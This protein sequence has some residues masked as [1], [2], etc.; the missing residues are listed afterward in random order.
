VRPELPDSQPGLPAGRHVALIVGAT[1]LLAIGV[2]ALIAKAAGFGEVRDATEEADTMWFVVCLLAEV[3]S[4]S[5]YAIVVREALRRE[6]EPTI[7][8]GLGVHITLASL[9]AIRI[10][11]AAGAGGLAVT[12]WCFPRARFSVDEAFVRVLGLNTLVYV[13]FGAGA[14]CAALVC[15]LGIWGNAPLALAMPWLVAAPFCYAAARFVIAPARVGRLSERRG[16]L[17]RRAFGYA[18]GGTAWVRDFIRTPGGRRA[19][20]AATV[21]W[22]GDIACLWAALHSIGIYLPLSELVLAYA[23]GYAATVLPLPF[24]G[25]GGVDAA[26]TFALT[27]SG[28]RSLPP[29]S[30]WRCTGSSVSGSRPFRPSRLSSSSRARAAAWSGWPPR[31]IP[32]CACSSQS[33]PR[34]CSLP[35]LPRRRPSGSSS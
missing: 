4:F 14:W 26:M 23:T 12:Y 13:V 21:Y 27:R 19:L 1:V 17:L 3:V 34:R 35:L 8:Y 2:V 18:V 32:P 29:S 11:A 31:N 22:A 6:G 15:A 9:G 24:A 30:Q 33:P 20:V 7:A 28:S 25:V 5:A 16:R 10:V